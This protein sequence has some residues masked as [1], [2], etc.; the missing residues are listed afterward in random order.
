MVQ[1]TIKYN[2][3]LRILKSGTTKYL[4]DEDLADVCRLVEC[5]AVDGLLALDDGGEVHQPAREMPPVKLDSSLPETNNCTE[6]CKE[7]CGS[8][9]RL[10][11]CHPSNWTRPFLNVRYKCIVREAICKQGCGSGSRKAKTTPEKKRKI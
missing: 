2:T 1:S 4:A 8:T 10:V 5:L 11:K 7:G 3:G 9:S 6:I